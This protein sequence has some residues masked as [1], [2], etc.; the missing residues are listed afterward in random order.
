MATLFSASKCLG[1]AESELQHLGHLG[2]GCPKFGEVGRHIPPSLLLS[3]AAERTLFLKNN[4]STAI[5]QRV[6]GGSLRILSDSWPT[7]PFSWAEVAQPCGEE[8]IVIGAE[9]AIA[10]KMR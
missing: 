4:L 7:S 2:K 10:P 1:I 9:G 8:D 3:I 5:A 6:F